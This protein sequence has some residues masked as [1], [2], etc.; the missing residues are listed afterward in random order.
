M[1]ACVTICFVLGCGGGE[2][3]DKHEAHFQSILDQ[4]NG[5]SD[6][7]DK[8]KDP[9]SANVEIPT[10]ISK[11]ETLTQTIAMTESL[12]QVGAASGMT[13]KDRFET[14]WKAKLEE[15][16]KR[17]EKSA[18]RAQNRV[19]NLPA[20]RQVEIRMKHLQ[21]SLEAFKDGYEQALGSK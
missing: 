1:F 19:G 15:A 21:T 13:L 18:K 11:V 14:H 12:P 3:T 6:S 20:L 2:T 4:T 9:T 10:I 8:L 5:L 16:F 7:F 17:L